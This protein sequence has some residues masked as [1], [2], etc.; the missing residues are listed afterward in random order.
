MRIC[1]SRSFSVGQGKHAGRET[2]ER[3]EYERS[4]DIKHCIDRL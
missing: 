4:P 2:S 3:S 1:S